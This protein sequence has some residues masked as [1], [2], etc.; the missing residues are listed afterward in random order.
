MSSFKTLFNNVN[1]SAGFAISE[2]KAKKKKKTNKV[3]EN[4]N[5]QVVFQN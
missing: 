5:K 2:M 1:T 4:S 3:V